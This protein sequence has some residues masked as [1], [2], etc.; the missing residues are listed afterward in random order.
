[1]NFCLFLWFFSFSLQSCSATNNKLGVNYVTI[2][3]LDRNRRA[4]V[5]GVFNRELWGNIQRLEELGFVGDGAADDNVN[6][7]KHLMFVFYHCLRIKQESF[8]A[9]GE[10]NREDIIDRILQYFGNNGHNPVQAAQ[11]LMYR[12]VETVTRHNQVA[13]KF[14]LNSFLTN[15]DPRRIRNID[16]IGDR[17]SPMVYVR[18]DRFLVEGDDQQLVGNEDQRR[19][20]IDHLLRDDIITI[21]LPYSIHLLKN[22]HIDKLTSYLGEGVANDRD[23]RRYWRERLQELP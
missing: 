16:D 7:R 12:A 17:R 10:V 5:N 21:E 23:S 6:I 22:I 13:V 2:E 19:M 8:N 3:H 11:G 9:F 14:I 4:P 1:M 20:D 18:D 15:D